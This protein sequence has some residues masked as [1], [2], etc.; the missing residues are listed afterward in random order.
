MFLFLAVLGPEMG[1]TGPILKVI[2]FQTGI[3]P[4]R[5]VQDRFVQ[6]LVLQKSATAQ[7][8]YFALDGDIRFMRPSVMGG[9]GEAQ[10]RCNQARRK[11]ATSG[12]ATRG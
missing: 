12:A 5:P 7:N 4:W 1:Q 8:M 10:P 3:L 6:H 11:L 9:E 2:P